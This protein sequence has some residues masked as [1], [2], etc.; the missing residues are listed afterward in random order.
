MKNIETILK[1]AGIELT[2]DQKAAVEKAVKENYKTLPDYQK[3]ADKVKS[4][5]D[6][7]ETTKEELK[8]FEGVDADALNQ[9]IKDLTEQMQKQDEDYKSKIADRDFNDM[10]AA[11][12]TKAKGRNAKAIKALLDIETL[13]S[14]KNQK[15]DVEKALKELAEA[16]DSKFLFG[17]A[18]DTSIG[19]GDPIGT[20]HK[21]G[22][23]DNMAAMRAA[24]GLPPEK[25]E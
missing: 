4:L 24:M 10:L 20:V 3:Q 19:T 15:E 2:D 18:D 23:K 8:K 7:L 22:E 13:K 1:E 11:G 14:S 25:K 21:G 17:D 16:Q 6:T 12:I 9:K 5:E